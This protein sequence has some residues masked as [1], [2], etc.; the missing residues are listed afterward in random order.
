MI[1]LQDTKEKKG[2]GFE[3]YEEI[4]VIRQSL[5]EGDYML[6]GNNDVVIER[7]ASTGELYLNL[8]NNQEKSRFY[9]E[10]ERLQK[11]K[12]PILMCEFPESRLYSF[13]KYS[14][15]PSSKHQYL[16]ITAQFLRKMIYELPEKFPP[17]KI[18]F[19]DNRVEAQ[20]FIIKT[21]KEVENGPTKKFDF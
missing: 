14:G 8:S 21:F 17:L 16:R 4:N 18:V 1:I 11:Y 20:D 5:P 12:H 2:L 19:C 7:K 6:H 9:R 15:I 10:L 3:L 13:P